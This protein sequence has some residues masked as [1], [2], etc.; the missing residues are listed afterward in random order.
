M[1]KPSPSLLSPH[2]LILIAMIVVVALTRLLPHPPNFTPVQAMALFAGASLLDR[3]L[4]V[5]VPLAA[6]VLSDLALGLLHGGFHMS[7]LFSLSHLSV[8][9]C[10]VLCAV[11]GFALRG[12]ISAGRV[13][14]WS[15]ASAVLFFVVTNFAVWL[16][17][18]AL[19]GYNACAA[20]LLPCYIAAIPFFQW[21]VAGALFYSALLFGGHH[22]L[23]QR[24]PALAGAH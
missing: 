12:R 19:P 22:L 7:Y 13:V 21:T 23:R 24:W 10:I 4:A 8:Y 15:L 2:S 3:R 1:T 14:G 9:A 6:M 20:G 18:S 16:S 5:L 17:A 11:A